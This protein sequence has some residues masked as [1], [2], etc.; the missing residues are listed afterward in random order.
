MRTFAHDGAG[1]TLIELLV[2]LMIF[3]MLAAAGVLLLGNSVSAQAQIKLRLDDMAAVQRAGG[4]LAADLGQ[5]VPRISRTEA[6]TLAPAF[7]SHREGESVPLLQFVRGGW[8]NLG[9]LPRPSLQ[10]VEYWVR[11]GRLERRTYAQVDGAAGDE[12]AA[13]LDHVENVAL[14]F[15]DAKGDWRD[16]WAPTQP[17]LMPRAVEMMVTR[18]GEPPVTLRF[19]VGPGPVE[20]LEGEAV[21]G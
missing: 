16:D 21:G 19:L 9:D 3:A 4:A 5:A 13:L 17:D 6:G 10:K 2:A 1:F 8:D 11:Q 18:T 7:W 14:R 15:R 20:K 12:P